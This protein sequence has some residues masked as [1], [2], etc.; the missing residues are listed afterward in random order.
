MWSEIKEWTKQWACVI[1]PRDRKQN[2]CCNRKHPYEE[3]K[4]RIGEGVPGWCQSRIKSLRWEDLSY[5]REN[6]RSV[7]LNIR[8]ICLKAK[9]YLSLLK[10][11]L[12]LWGKFAYISMN[13]HSNP[14]IVKDSAWHS[15]AAMRLQ[16]CHISLCV[17]EGSGVTYVLYPHL[18][19]DTALLDTCNNI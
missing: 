7:Y 2:S 14:Y 19:W 12:T 3:A 1:M 16:Q 11:F 8:F 10:S 13:K 5:L 18:C 17:L 6:W 15:K 4:W 9:S